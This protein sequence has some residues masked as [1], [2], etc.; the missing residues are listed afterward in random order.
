MINNNSKRNKN[1]F[2]NKL[3]HLKEEMIYLR[4]NNSSQNKIKIIDLKKQFKK[5][6]KAKIRLYEKGEFYK[7]SKVIGENNSEN[8]F[9][10]LKNITKSKEI[11]IQIEIEEIADSYS[12]IFNDN[13][14]VPEEQVEMVN[15]EILS[16][17]IK[18]CN[19]IKLSL[20]EFR[21]AFNSTSTSKACGNDNTLLYMIHNL[22]S[23]FIDKIVFPFFTNIHCKK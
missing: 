23:S 9:K 11:K 22:E 7:I 12:N 5:E 13:L 1:W 19:S 10:N 16:I 8:F 17:N 18:N 20:E 6:M 2:T 14:K 4:Y 15:R 3:K 21:S